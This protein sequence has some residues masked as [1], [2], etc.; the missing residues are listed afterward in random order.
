MQMHEGLG[1]LVGVH[2]RPSQQDKKG[3]DFELLARHL[4]R[5]MQMQHPGPKYEVHKTPT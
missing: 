2:Y 4:Q 5:V 1:V 3:E